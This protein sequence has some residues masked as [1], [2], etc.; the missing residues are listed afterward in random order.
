MSDYKPLIKSGKYDTGTLQI[1]AQSTDTVKVY[2]TSLNGEYDLILTDI[3]LLTDGVAG[4]E[5][6]CQIVSDT[7]RTDKG[8]ALSGSAFQNDLIKLFHRNGTPEMTSPL[9]LRN[10]VIRNWMSI[11]LQQVGVLGI[12]INTVA[13]NLLLTFEYKRL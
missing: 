6:A 3:K 4:D 13:H 8:T 9:L 10:Q 5:Y 12:D 2:S 1:F 11:S 7:L